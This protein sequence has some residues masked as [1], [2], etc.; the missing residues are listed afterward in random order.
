LYALAEMQDC[1]SQVPLFAGIDEHNLSALAAVTVRT[2]FRKEQ[3]VWRTG[4]SSDQ[5]Y[6]VLSGMIKRTALSAGGNE[7]VLELLTAGDCLGAPELLAGRC[8]STSAIAVKPTTVLTIAGERLRCVMEDAPRLALRMGRFLAVRQLVVEDEFTTSQ[9]RSSGERVLEYFMQQC[10][11]P[12]NSSGETTLQLPASKQLIASRIGISPE[13]LSRALREL[14][15]SGVLITYGSVVRLQNAPL[16]LRL[17]RHSPGVSAVTSILDQAQL[18][19]L[20]N[21]AGRQRMLSQRMAKSWLMLGCGVLPTRARKMLSQSV[22]LFEQQLTLLGK[23]AAN[24][25]IIE[26][27]Q[28]LSAV[29]RPYRSALE[30]SPH[31]DHA[32]ALYMLNEDLLRAAEHHTSAFARILPTSRSALVNLAGRQRMLAQRIAKLYLFSRYQINVGTC[33]TE[34]AVARQQFDSASKQLLAAAHG[35]A[36]INSVLGKI[37]QSWSSLQTTLD[38][39]QSAESARMI[40]E[41]SEHLVRQADCAVRWYESND[42]A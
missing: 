29:W 25:E 10:A 24:D 3:V 18:N 9:S 14:A 40:C 22:E 32:S 41:T 31:S 11:Q 38:E 37:D 33:R 2:N 26:A 39:V 4:G 6:V 17:R 16:H 42:A 35:D 23:V 27:H 28:M 30:Q 1:L 13:T 12:L 36:S 8:Y 15:D 5:L 19:S 20:I 34:M 7:R 21:I